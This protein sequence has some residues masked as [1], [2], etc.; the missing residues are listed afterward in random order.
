MP[1]PAEHAHSHGRRERTLERAATWL[2]LACAVHCLLVPVAM[3]VLPLFGATGALAVDDHAELTLTLLVLGSALAGMVW[4]YRR[5]GNLRLVYATLSGL[6]AY[7]LG[8]L[9]HESW[10]GV[11]LAVAGALALAASSFV[12]ARLSHQC[13]DASCAS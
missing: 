4:G 8:H 7:L 1:S 2:S 12:S 6:S 5:H 11:V 3:S 10:Y 13:E 9:F